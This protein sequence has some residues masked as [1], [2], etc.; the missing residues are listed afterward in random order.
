METITKYASIGLAALLA[1]A[2]IYISILSNQRDSAL[3]KLDKANKNIEQL[4]QANLNLAG[5]IDLLESQAQQNRVYITEL[6]AKRTE[7]EK[8]ATKLVQEF[9][10]KKHENQTINNWASKPLP[11]GLY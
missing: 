7:T 6:E 8:Q 10:I 5:S 3:D 2:I 4:Q 9:K 1:I 11:S